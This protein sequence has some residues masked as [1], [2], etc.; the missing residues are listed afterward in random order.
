MSGGH[1]DYKQYHIG[2][3]AE[4]I[5][6]LIDRNGKLKDKEELSSWDIDDGNFNHY[7]YPDEIISKFKEAVIALKSAHIYAQRADWLLSGDDS[8]ETFI[9]RLNQELSESNTRI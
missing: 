7:K 8:E 5:Q 1:F 4:S 6:S 2:E 3:I 9:K